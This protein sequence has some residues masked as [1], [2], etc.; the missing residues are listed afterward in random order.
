MKSPD[1]IN[2]QNLLPLVG[3]RVLDRRC[4]SCDAGVVDQH[5]EPAQR[6]DGSGNHARDFVPL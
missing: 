3:I 4:R 5:I 2:R 6:P 1:D